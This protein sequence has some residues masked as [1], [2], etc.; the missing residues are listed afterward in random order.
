MEVETGIKSFLRNGTEWGALSGLVTIQNG[1]MNI[2]PLKGHVRGG[3]AKGHIR[4]DAAHDPARLDA[5]FE[6]HKLGYSASPDGD[7]Q[8]DV[9][10]EATSTGNNV[11]AL[12]GNLQGKAAIMA[13]PGGLTGDLAESWTKGLLPDDARTLDCGVAEFV[14]KGPIAT[15]DKFFL[16]SG[17]LT[18]SGKGVW[19]L[20][21]GVLDIRRDSAVPEKDFCQGVLN[22]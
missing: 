11:D 7:G 8:A 19:N 6:V 15:A 18:V 13:G 16:D 9:A 17:D 1:R 20:R 21:Q 3:D 2:D 5:A 4:L 14:V 22:K 12:W 10:M